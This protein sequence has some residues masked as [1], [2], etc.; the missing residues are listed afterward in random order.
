MDM[1]VN[2][3][4][5]AKLKEELDLLAKE[6]C[7]EPSQQRKGGLPGEEATVVDHTLE[8]FVQVGREIARLESLLETVRTERNMYEEQRNQASKHF[9]SL[10]QTLK[11]TE[12]ERDK[13]K[14]EV[15]HWEGSV[16]HWRELA[17]QAKAQALA[18]VRE[19]LIGENSMLAWQG[20]GLNVIPET[21][22]EILSTL[23]DI[24]GEKE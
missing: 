20:R 4:E 1:A 12:S 2:P 19:A 15:E 5:W 22:E 9:D 18:E 8:Q 10:V 11:E 7:F 14:A 16:R 13:A 24:Q 21:F 3:A 6:T 23:E 17:D